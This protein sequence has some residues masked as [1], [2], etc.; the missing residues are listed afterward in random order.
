MAQLIPNGIKLQTVLPVGAYCARLEQTWGL[1]LH[2]TLAYT[3]LVWKVPR[4]LQMMVYPGRRKIG[5]DMD[6]LGA[7]ANQRSL[8]ACGKCPG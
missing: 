6:S 7:Y 4:G 8:T 2:P 5:V 1:Y 3:W